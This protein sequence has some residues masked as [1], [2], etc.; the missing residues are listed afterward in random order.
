MPGRSRPLTDDEREGIRLAV[1]SALRKLK[2]L[3]ANIVPVFEDYEHVG[4]A[5]LPG[6]DHSRV[7]MGARARVGRQPGAEFNPVR[8]RMMVGVARASKRRA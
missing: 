2:N 8:E 6:A 5:D 7:R 3:Y 4:R 1:H